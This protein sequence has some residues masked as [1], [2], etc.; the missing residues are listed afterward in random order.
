MFSTKEA[1]QQEEQ[2]NDKI[3]GALIEELQ[4]FETLFIVFNWYYLLLYI[5]IYFLLSA[6][7]TADSQDSKWLNEQIKKYGASFTDTYIA[8]SM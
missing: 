3:D 6:K 2:E 7:E 5:Y 8:D 1:I 4:Q